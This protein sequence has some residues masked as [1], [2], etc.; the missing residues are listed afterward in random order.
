MFVNSIW[1]GTVDMEIAA[2]IDILLVPLEVLVAVGGLG[3]CVNSFWKEGVGLGTSAST[4]ILAAG[5]VGGRVTGTSHLMA[6]REVSD[7]YNM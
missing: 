4:F 2:D 1:K 6:I 3:R 7:S 5:E